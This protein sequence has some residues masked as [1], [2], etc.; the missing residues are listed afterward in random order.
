MA[1]KN[2]Q[3]GWNGIVQQRLISDQIGAIWKLIKIVKKK[4]D[5][6]LIN[7]RH[8]SQY[9]GMTEQYSWGCSHQFHMVEM[10]LFLGFQIPKV[11]LNY[12]MCQKWLTNNNVC[13]AA[14]ITFKSLFEHVEHPYISTTVP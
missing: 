7:Q 6:L 1:I 2:H 9:T 11:L 8:G 12:K 14:W 4:T 10:W 13:P 5:N 3:L